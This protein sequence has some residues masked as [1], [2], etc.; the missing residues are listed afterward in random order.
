MKNKKR[1]ITMIAVLVF[2][3]A[4]VALNWSYNN[5]WGHPDSEMVSVSGWV[6]EQF[7]R[8]PEAGDCFSRDGWEV[9]VTRAE[10]HRVSEI[11]LRRETQTPAP[12]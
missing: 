10:R 1:N 5:R 3:C 12:V 4:A 2:V 6:M 7:G 9:R 11:Q 8:V